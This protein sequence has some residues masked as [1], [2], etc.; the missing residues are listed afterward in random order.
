MNQK[1]TALLLIDVL[2]EVREK[3]DPEMQLQTLVALLTTAAEPGITMKDLS[4]LRG[5]SQSAMSRNVDTLGQGFQRDGKGLGLLIAREDP[6]ERRRKVLQ[7]TP[8]GER[9]MGDLTDKLRAALKRI[10]KKS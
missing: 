8:K 5:I 6:T 7:L 3:V 2:Q 4:Q 9:L 10:E 1:D